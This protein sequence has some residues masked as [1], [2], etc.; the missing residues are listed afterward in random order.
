MNRY[1]EQ[2]LRIFPDDFSDR[3]LLGFRIQKVAFDDLGQNE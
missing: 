3:M 2:I 1:F